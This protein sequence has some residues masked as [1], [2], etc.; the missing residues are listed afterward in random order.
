MH[1]LKKYI[2]HT[3]DAQERNFTGQLYCA[4]LVTKR[5][6]LRFLYRTFGTPNF[7]HPME[8]ASESELMH[9]CCLVVRRAMGRLDIL[10]DINIWKYKHM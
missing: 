9:Q 3:L 4:F 7:P 2:L 1:I 10:G 6:L 8:Y 5:N